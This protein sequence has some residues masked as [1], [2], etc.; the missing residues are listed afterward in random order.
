[1][2]SS[3]VMVRTI[4]TLLIILCRASFIDNGLTLLLVMKMVNLL[5]ALGDMTLSSG[6]I[7]D[8]RKEN[9]KNNHPSRA[10]RRKANQLVFGYCRS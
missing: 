1:M 3:L 10:V 6:L 9:G 8:N 5:E 4:A 2:L 7:R